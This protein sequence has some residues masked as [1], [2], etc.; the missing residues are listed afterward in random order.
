[1][2]AVLNAVAEAKTELLPLEKELFRNASTVYTG[3]VI[4]P[5]FGVYRELAV[6]RDEV[7][8]GSILIVVT[9]RSVR[10]QPI[11]PRAAHSMCCNVDVICH[12]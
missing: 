8:P 10:L 11:T 4:L 3:P 2:Y 12:V 5:L 1:M 9:Q 7:F 6:T